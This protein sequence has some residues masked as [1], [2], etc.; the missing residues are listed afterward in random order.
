MSDTYTPSLENAIAGHFDF[1]IRSILGEAWKKTKG[2]KATYWKALILMLLVTLAI[3][4]VEFFAG[5][6]IGVIGTL[7]NA[8]KITLHQIAA[9]ANEIFRV[10]SIFITAP[11]SAGI[12]MIGIKHCCYEESSTAKSIF[13]YYHYWR[14]LWVYPVLLILLGIIDTIAIILIHTLLPA[15]P[16]LAH[17]VE[18]LVHIVIVV[19]FFYFIVSWFLF[20]LLVVEK[21]LNT[22]EA[23]SASRKA[24]GHHW[25]KTF[26][27]LLL[28]GA[29]VIGSLLTLGILLIWT[30][31]MM[32]NSMAILYREIF[33]TQKNPSLNTQN[34]LEIKP[35]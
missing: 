14:R 17:L 27:F 25:F 5:I 35:L 8:E 3:L 19:L 1:R 12:L 4:A 10:L 20:P 15:A 21:Q 11:L 30:L 16:T 26:G 34:E 28:S 7:L 23:L 31:P 29:I 13:Y 6:I 9:I 24:I 18:A 33:G 2:I 22:R 32:N